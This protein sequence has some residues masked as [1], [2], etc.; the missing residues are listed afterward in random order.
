MSR[1]VLLR[2]ALVQTL[3][4]GVLSVALAVPLGESFFKRW[5][6][7]VGPVAWM[8]C[9]LLTARVLDLPRWRTLVG[10]VLAGLPSV[11]LV[12]LGEHTAGD[13]VAIVAFAF[14]CA[15]RAPLPLAVTER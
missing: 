3:L 1:S 14:W 12:L 9:S 8:A 15:W 11:A 7:I 5:G 4:V 2:V 6:W 10:A 13:V